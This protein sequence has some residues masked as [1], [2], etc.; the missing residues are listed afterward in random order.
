MP[1]EML[2]CEYVAFR[3]LLI[4]CAPMSNQIC[5]IQIESC[6]QVLFM[7][8]EGAVS[9]TLAATKSPTEVS[10]VEFGFVQTAGESEVCFSDQIFES[11]LFASDQ[12]G[13]V[14]PDI[15]SLSS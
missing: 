5:T 10:T 2:I 1:P 15:T 3:N 7:A 6:I 9:V 14:F 13:R 12:T 8:V 4:S 11:L